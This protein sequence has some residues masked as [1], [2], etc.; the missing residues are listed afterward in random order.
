MHD[1]NNNDK[2]MR[3]MMWMM[4]I[5]CAVLLVLILLFGA[6]G[7]ALGLP[8][9]IVLGGIAT[10]FIVHFF[11]MGRSYQHSDGKQANAQEED[12]HKGKDH[13]GHGCCH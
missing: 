3:S 13:S 11:M 7:R 1:H 2:G 12:A 8:T 10:M 6:G 5:C 4:V 9:W